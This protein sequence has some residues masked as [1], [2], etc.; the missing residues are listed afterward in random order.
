MQH[1]TDTIL[2]KT[3]QHFMV[4]VGKFLAAFL[5]YVIIVLIAGYIFKLSILTQSIVLLVIAVVVFVWYYFFWV[6]SYFLISNEKIIA[7][8]RNGLFSKWHMSIHYKNIRDT[9]FA[10]NNI[11]HY[12]F[13]YGTLFA[14]SSAGSVGDFEARCVPGVEKAYKIINAL[15]NFTEEERKQITSLDQLTHPHV[16][17]KADETIQQAVQKETEILLD[18]KGI[19]EVIVVND[20]DRRM[21]FEMEEDRN[22]GVYESLRKQ[23]LFAV[24]HDSSFREPDEAIVMKAGEKVI[25]PTVKF[26]EIKRPSVISSSPGKSVHNYLVPKFNNLGEYDATLLIGFDQ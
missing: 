1:Y 24:T 25:F 13:N 3:H 8:V 22:H 6:K 23:I 18:I 10:K 16:K 2:Y 4:L 26:H 12:M 17:P 11:L 20:A 21:I 19:K 5:V 14:R 9:A 15:H 7:K